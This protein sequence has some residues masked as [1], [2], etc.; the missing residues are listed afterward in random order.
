MAATRAIAPN[1]RAVYYCPLRERLPAIRIPL[2]PSD[3]D[4][5]LDI[6]PFINRCYEIGRYWQS[7]A[8][9]DLAATLTSKEREWSE[10]L[11][12]LAGLRGR[13]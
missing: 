10:Q 3:R 1:H 8:E 4:V 2:R 9:S 13:K 7:V 5:V 12:L 11:L 6:Q